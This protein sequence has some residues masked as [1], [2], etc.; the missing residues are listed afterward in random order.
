MDSRAS[1]CVFVIH[2][3]DGM[4]AWC[5]VKVCVLRV[6]MCDFSLQICRVWGKS[7][8]NNEYYLYS[9]YSYIYILSNAMREEN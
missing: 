2:Q 9:V 8:D 7:F 1:V 5:G 6:S 3:M 4:S